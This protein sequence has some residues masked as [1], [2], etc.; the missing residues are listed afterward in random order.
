MRGDQLSGATYGVFLGFVISVL[1]I[2]L[3]KTGWTVWWGALAV[4]QMIEAGVLWRRTALAAMTSSS[5]WAAGMGFAFVLLALYG[6]SFPDVFWQHPVGLMLALSISPFLWFLEKRR[7]PLQWER[8]KDE[9]ARASLRD[10]L[11]FRH[12]PDLRFEPRC[13]TGVR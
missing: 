6:L 12:I 9:R 10:I 7:H 1:T 4:Q 11:M 8:L 3:P 13:P 5:L 2:A